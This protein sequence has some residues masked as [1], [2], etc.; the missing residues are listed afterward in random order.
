MILD[1]CGEKIG[2]D[3]Y[4]ISFYS[5]T[6]ECKTRSEVEEKLE[7]LREKIIASPTGIWEEF[8]RE[9]YKKIIASQEEKYRIF[10][11]NEYHMAKIFA[12]D[13]EISSMVIKAE[14]MRVAV[15]EEDIQKIRNRLREKGYFWETE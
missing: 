9:S 4:Y 14:G 10:K 5:L 11:I 15:K 3:T 7:L 8:F 6:K 1:R 2:D 12:E 13:H